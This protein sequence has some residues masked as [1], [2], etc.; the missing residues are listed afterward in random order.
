MSLPDTKNSPERPKLFNITAVGV[1]VTVG[2]LTLAVVL[3]ALL[4]GIWLDGKFDTRPWFTL[5]L[6]ILSIPVSLLV[7]VV[8]ARRAILKIRSDLEKPK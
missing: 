3:I 6:V 1:I 7:I 8:V 5:G 2:C 4:T